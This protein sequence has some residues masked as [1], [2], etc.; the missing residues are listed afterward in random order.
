MSTTD[1]PCRETG[2][3]VFIKTHKTGSTTL[4]SITSRFGYFRNLSFL[5]GTDTIIGH[6]YSIR[7]DWKNLKILPPIG[8]NP[9][10]YANYRNYNISDVHILFE[11]DKME[12][13]MNPAPDLKYISIVREPT[14]QWLSNFQYY[15]RYQAIG[16]TL[17]TLNKTLLP[18]LKSDDVHKL[19]FNRQSKDLGIGPDILWSNSTKLL[20][21]T[22]D[23]LKQ[24][25][26][27]V[28]I[29]EYFDESLV[30][31]KQIFCWSFDDILYVKK[32][33]QPTPLVVN[34]ETRKEI[35][36]HNWLDEIIYEYYL[37]EFWKKVKDYGPTFEKDLRHFRALLK[38]SSDNCVEKSLVELSNDKHVYIQHYSTRNSSLFC[39]ALVN[40]KFHMDMKMIQR[41]GRKS[42]KRWAGLAIH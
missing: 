35:Q 10:D 14:A 37:E 12:R 24:L 11:P 6:I 25:L 39:W 15:K 31:L 3:F 16:L 38:E 13:L 42:D 9:G 21:S 32:R 40:T 27:F 2:N 22:L 23:K 26:S 1:E 8:I 4:R 7:F 41:Q 19:G 30:I 18:F 28:L 20:K 36:K 29:T 5:L 33:A 17:T 34:I